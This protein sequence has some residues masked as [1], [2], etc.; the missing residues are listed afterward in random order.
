MLGV[1]F[2]LGE[3]AFVAYSAAQIPDY[4]SLPWYV[5]TGYAGER[6]MMCLWHG[7]MTCVFVMGLQ[8]R[9][10]WRVVGYLAAISLR[11]LGNA[12]PVLAGLGFIPARVTYL[13]IT[14]IFI[15][16]A[17]LF[18]RLRRQVG[19]ES[20]ITQSAPRPASS[21]VAWRLLPRPTRH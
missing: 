20:G 15:R 12:A 10:G 4:A 1:S 21:R 9:G 8:R 11:A 3:A 7:I 2:G 5:L 6:F 16:A 19:R 17:F 13:W 18:E 14:G